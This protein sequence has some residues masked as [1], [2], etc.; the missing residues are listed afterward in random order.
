MSEDILGWH[1]WMGG[2]TGIQWIDT[3]NASKRL[4]MHST[5]SRIKNYLAEPRN[6]PMHS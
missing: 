2:A 3:K 1:D 5:N 4:T 6:K